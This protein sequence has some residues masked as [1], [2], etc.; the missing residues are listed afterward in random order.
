[1][2]RRVGWFGR[3]TWSLGLSLGACAALAQTPPS[4]AFLPV[5][6]GAIEMLLRPRSIE[7]IARETDSVRARLAAAETD[8]TAAREQL[9]L[10]RGRVK[11]KEQEIA[12][13]KQQAKF[14]KQEND[15]A[16]RAA[17]E[18]SLDNERERLGVFERVR[19]AF[20]TAVERAEA[21]VGFH[22]SRIEAHE[23]ERQIAEIDNRRVALRGLSTVDPLELE[24]LERKSRDA[25]RTY[26]KRLAKSGAASAKLAK[27]TERLAERK[28]DLLEAWEEA[29]IRPRA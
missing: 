12:L 23:A 4:E 6:D 20:A 1:M 3:W 26:L 14:A 15:A 7:E 25:V 8:A 21:A 11:V 10:A 22:R 27:A 24:G 17:I 2:R 9:T 16:R 13:L 29:G 5:D 19:D 28:L 18:A